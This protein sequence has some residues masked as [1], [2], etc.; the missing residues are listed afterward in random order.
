MKVLSRFA[1]P[2]SKQTAWL[3]LASMACMPF[4][5]AAAAE[6]PE[7][8][9][10]SAV[11]DRTRGIRDEERD[12][13]FQL[14]DYAAAGN[15]EAQA[16]AAARNLTGF[17]QEFREEQER[18]RAKNPELPRYR[19]SLYA[20][21]LKNPQRYRGELLTL[22]GHIRRLEK[23]PLID[24]DE[25]RG[26]AFQSYL[27]TEDSRSHPYIIVTRE[28]ADG[29]PR[30]NVL[31]EATVTGYFLKIYA[32]DAQ[33]AARV[34]PLILAGRLQWRPREKPAPLIPTVWG[35]VIAGGVVLI[36]VLL[37][38]RIAVKDR[39]VRLAHQKKIAESAE[40]FSAEE[41]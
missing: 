35:I 29:M 33:D 13:Y 20:D 40:P 1:N 26:V 2:L 18:A 34:A 32:Y 10:L 7:F 17:E 6:E 28:V 22:S 4:C 11:Q 31:E 38:A 15:P 41:P 25:D 37:L 5:A 8:P 3:I 30:G 16:A 12:A 39:Q 19:Y 24:G 14:L 27:F 36:L 21:L 9:D 23:M